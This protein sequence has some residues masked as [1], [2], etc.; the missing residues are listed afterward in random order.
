[1]RIDFS[2]LLQEVSSPQEQT[3]SWFKVLDSTTTIGL[4]PLLWAHALIAS[5][6]LPPILERGLLGSEILLLIAL[7]RRF[8]TINT[9]GELSTMTRMVLSLAKDPVLGPLLT[10]LIT[11]KLVASITKLTSEVFSAI[12]VSKLEDLLSLT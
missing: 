8:V 1:M 3:T 10:T 5:I 9:H 4:P 2:W 11:I 12:I 6:P 7:S